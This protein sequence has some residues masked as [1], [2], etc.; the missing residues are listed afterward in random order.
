MLRQTL[1]TAAAAF[2]LSMLITAEAAATA[3]RTF[4]ASYGN[5]ANP[6]SLTLPCRAFAAA[7]AQTTSGGEVIVLDSAG[8]GPVTVTQS[9]SIIAPAG[10]YAGIS[11]PGGGT[12]ITITS[13]GVAVVLRG[14]TIVGTG[15][16]LRMTNGSRLTVER[17]E[18]AG[19]VYGLALN[20]ANN[21]VFI[22][23]TTIRDNLIGIDMT[24]STNLTMDRSRVEANTGAGLQGINGPTV[25]ISNSVFARNQG[26]AVWIMGGDAALTIS[27]TTISDNQS[28]IQTG[29]NVGVPSY[30]RIIRGTIT[31]NSEGIYL[32]AHAKATIADSLIAG[33]MG[34]GLLVS[35]AGDSNAVSATVTGN[36]ITNNAKGI[37]VFMLGELRTSQDNIVDSNAVD[38]DSSTGGVVIPITGK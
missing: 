5:D 22:N 30:L 31:N 21:V 2:V 25:S 18:F 17:C 3:Q 1:A 37:W 34:Y 35:G 38:I 7:I 14:L 32:V 23:D 26:S 24:E 15:D 28:A 6:C 27:D 29:G 12:G 4:V 20:V 33:N 36:R 11:V 9:V 13:T 16:G 19:L 8:Y 10:V